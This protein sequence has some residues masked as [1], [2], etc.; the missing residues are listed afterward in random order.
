MKRVAAPGQ[1]SAPYFDTPSDATETPAYR[2]AQMSRAACEAELKAR[3]IPFRRVS[4]RGVL[5]PVR[6]TGRLRGILFQGEGTDQTRARSPHEIIDCRLVLALHDSAEILAEHDIVEVRHYSIYRFPEPS[7]PSSKPASR[8]M[9]A[10]ALD[11]GLFIKKDGTILNVDKHFH[12]AIGAKTCGPGARPRPPTAPALEL[13][14]ILC[15][16]VSRRLFT[17]VLTPNYNAPH[18]NHFH[19]EVA[20]DKKWFLVH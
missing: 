11:A 14:E 3:H 6:L 20:A 15:K 7:W 1:W 2:Y 4:A 18:K 17:V 5:A 9:G 10:L 16:L 8:H 12:G 19:L 13:R